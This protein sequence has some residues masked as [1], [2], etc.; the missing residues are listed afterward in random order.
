M[1]GYIFKGTVSLR[2]ELKLRPVMTAKLSS[3]LPMQTLQKMLTASIHSPAPRQ[4]ILSL[5]SRN[6]WQVQPLW[7]ELHNFS[8]R[9]TFTFPPTSVGKGQLCPR[10]YGE[11]LVNNSTFGSAGAFATAGFA[12]RLIRL[13]RIRHV[14]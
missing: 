7:K 9:N 10:T 14:M 13:K 4:V 8:I 3:L 12:I 6:R 1:E 5:Q 2:P 11:N